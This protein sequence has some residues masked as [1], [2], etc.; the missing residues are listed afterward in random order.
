M[1]VHLPSAAHFAAAGAAALF[2]FW[3]R[4]CQKIRIGL[5]MKIEE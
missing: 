2:P 5:A 1:P 4:S 3:N